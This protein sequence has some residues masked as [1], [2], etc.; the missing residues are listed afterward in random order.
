MPEEAG[1]FKL[2]LEKF[3]FNEAGFRELIVGPIQR[4]LVRRAIRVEAAA[5]EYAT[6]RGGGPK[7]RTGRL[8][9]SIT[10]KIGIDPISPYVDVGSNVLY[11]PF[12]ELGHKNT[13]HQYRAAGG[14]W[15]YVGDKPAKAYPFLR[16]AL[17]A[18]RVTIVY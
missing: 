9:S 1:A 12:V 14:G 11:A 7:V 16:P 4:D 8:R 18:A 5:K 3:A 6:G 13:P 10:W 2:N 15:G 17:E